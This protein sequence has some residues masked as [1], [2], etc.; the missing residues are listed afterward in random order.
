MMK[1][2]RLFLLALVLLT[3]PLYAVRSGPFQNDPGD[4]GSGG[5]GGS[6]TCAVQCSDG[7]W[8]GIACNTGQTAHCACDGSPLRARPY[9]T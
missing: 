7:S 5:G 9:C 2:I 8:S 3:M 1:K 4:G 6:T